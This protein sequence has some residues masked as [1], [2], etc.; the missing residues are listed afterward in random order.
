[1]ESHSTS[2]L[3]VTHLNLPQSVATFLN[4]NSPSKAVVKPDI[5]SATSWTNDQGN[6]VLY[7]STWTQE[8]GWEIENSTATKGSTTSMAGSSTSNGISIV[9]NGTDRGVLNL[10]VIQ[11]EFDDVKSIKAIETWEPPRSQETQSAVLGVD[12]FE[13]YNRIA[14]VSEGG[15]LDLAVVRP[16][17]FSTPWSNSTTSCAAY[18][19]VKFLKNPNKVIV[20]GNKP[21]TD[22]EVWDVLASN[23]APVQTLTSSSSNDRN[24]YGNNCICT[25]PTRPEIVVTGQPTGGIKVWD[26]RKQ[27]TPLLKSLIGHTLD[28]WDLK[29]H[30]QNP[31]LLFSV[32][33]DGNILRWD[34]SGNTD[35]SE[36][37]NS[38]SSMLVDPTTINNNS[39][40]AIESLNLSYDILCS[41]K[42]VVGNSID[43][44]GMTGSMVAA[45][46]DGCL[47]CCDDV[48]M[49]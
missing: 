24:S 11:K 5:V 44:C 20:V 17:G 41:S 3:R 31:S 23:H 45:Y 49:L 46:D 22:L 18:N 27:N 2:S 28:V 21:K 37:S 10:N 30:P 32:G 33:H 26:I 39:N 15:A 34:V 36:D 6:G 16:S 13:D 8:N 47:I 7:L 1:M 25:H 29:F 9:V 40:M 48:E 4:S 35:V 43:I 19:D 14:S 12:I 42:G 38:N